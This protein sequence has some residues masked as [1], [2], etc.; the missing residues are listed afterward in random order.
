MSDIDREVEEVKSDWR[1][2]R[3]DS[4]WMRGKSVNPNS[5]TKKLYA[6]LEKMTREI[7]KIEKSYLNPKSNQFLQRASKALD[8]PQP[9]FEDEANKIRDV[10]FPKGNLREKLTDE[11]IA[12]ETLSSIPNDALKKILSR[13]VSVKNVDTNKQSDTRSLIS[14]PRARKAKHVLKSGNHLSSKLDKRKLDE[15][16][17]KSTLLNDQRSSKEMCADIERYLEQYI[18][19]AEK[20]FVEES[21]TR[22]LQPSSEDMTEMLKR[23]NL[24]SFNMYDIADCRNDSEKDFSSNSAR[25]VKNVRLEDSL[26]AAVNNKTG[27]R[28]MF[29]ETTTQCVSPKRVNNSVQDNGLCFDTSVQTNIKFPS[30][31]NAFIGM[32]LGALN[33]DIPTNALSRILQSEY[34]KKDVSLKPM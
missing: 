1:M 14:N 8:V 4:G 18:N 10:L 6:T 20:N 28:K 9:S 34:L 25:R 21:K 23:L 5:R 27:S 32:G 29:K 2:L 31:N 7:S 15:I 3:A 26:K 16:R 17:S 22:N 33:T 30:K 19:N 12:D 24:E 13:K 11:K